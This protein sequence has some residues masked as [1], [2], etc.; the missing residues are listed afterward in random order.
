M[1]RIKRISND[2]FTS[3]TYLLFDNQYLY[4]WLIDIGDYDKVADVIPPQMEIRGLFLTHT[5]FDHTYGINALHRS[6]PNCRIFTSA[7]GGE[8]LY[9]DKK[10][11]SRYHEAAF[12]YE[13]ENVTVL[14][15][16]SILEL[17][18]G[19][20]LKVYATP[21]HC[22]SCLTFEVGDYLFTGDSYIPGVKVVTKL[23]KGDRALAR[24]S[25]K[26]ILL[27]SNG[28]T[29][30][31]GHGDVFCFGEVRDFYENYLNL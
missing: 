28:K 20:P 7:Y 4:C 17:Y 23:P 30:C 31:P 2:V 11:F 29:I 21:G 19:T 13:G 16:G 9:D 8:A 27:L 24:Q 1:L 3:N 12:T 26:R 6:H 5:H 14:G 10:N 22:P 25:L 18:P 15:E